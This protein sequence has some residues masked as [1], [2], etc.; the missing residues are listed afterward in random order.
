MNAF[1]ILLFSLDVGY[2]SAALRAGVSG[3][4]V[5]WEC[6]DKEGRQEGYDT[7]INRGGAADLRAMRAAA[8]GPVL[9]RINNHPALRK[10][11]VR[12][13]IA[14]GADEILAAHGEDDP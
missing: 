8:T 6:V 10:V 7:E 11:E 3:V 1:E 13:A 5:D 2:S 12:M 14:A 9:C 4:I